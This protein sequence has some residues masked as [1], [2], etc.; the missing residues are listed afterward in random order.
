MTKHIYLVHGYQSS[1]HANWFDWLKTQLKFKNQQQL[2]VLHLPTPNHPNPGAWDHACHTTI[3]ANGD[4]ILIGH[5]L[6]CMQILRFLQQ[7]PD[8]KQVNVILVGGFSEHLTTLPEL[9]AFTNYQLNF[10]QLKQQISHLTVFAAKNDAIVNFEYTAKLAHNLNGS[11]VLLP[12]GHHFMGSEGYVKLPV[13][14]NELLK[15]L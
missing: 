11:F 15:I 13:V 7:H 8:L 9:D 1:P 10:Q 14:Y 2:N 5:S 6:G 12:T 4:L 3:T